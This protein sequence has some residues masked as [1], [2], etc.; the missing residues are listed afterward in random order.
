MKE[1]VDIVYEEFDKKRKKEDLLEA[2]QE[3]LKEL[4]ELENKLKLK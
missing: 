4:E 3:D 2:D 1:K